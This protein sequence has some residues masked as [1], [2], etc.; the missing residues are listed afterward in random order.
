MLLYNGKIHFAIVYK[1]YWNFSAPS[2]LFY[3]E[4]KDC[5]QEFEYALNE[6]KV[7]VA[8][9]QLKDNAA[10]VGTCRHANHMAC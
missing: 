7:I 4:G 2:W 5:R 1:E 9:S 10:S 8:I 3:G 6:E